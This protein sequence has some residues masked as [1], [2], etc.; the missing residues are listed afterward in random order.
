[1]ASGQVWMGGG[2]ISATD[3]S[4][5]K[6]WSPEFTASHRHN[7]LIAL[8]HRR[9]ILKDAQVWILQWTRTSDIHR[10]DRKILDWTSD[11]LVGKG[12]RAV[13]CHLHLPHVWSNARISSPFHEYN[14]YPLCKQAFITSIIAP[15]KQPWFGLLEIFFTIWLIWLNF[16]DNG[17]I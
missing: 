4:I 15:S 3:L 6:A 1:M 11:L 9:P 16:G 14:N 12:L 10:L 13:L 17:C 5:S 7:V 8:S 2:G